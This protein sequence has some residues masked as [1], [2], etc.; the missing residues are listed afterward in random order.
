VIRTAFIDSDIILD[1][2]TGRQPFLDNSAMVLSIIEG[3]L[4][5]GMVS[6]NI[7]TNVFYILRKL[8]SGEKAKKFLRSFLEYVTVIPVDHRTVMD[9]LN[10]DISD[11]EDAVQHF[12]AL[13]NNCDCIVTRNIDDYKTAKLNVYSPVDFLQFFQASRFDGS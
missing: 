10:S 5:A 6:S 1:V 8:S 7:I 3:G 9:A 12:A 13:S 4:V 2:A 11:F